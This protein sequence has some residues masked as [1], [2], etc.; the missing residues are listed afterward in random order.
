VPHG[1]SVAADGTLYLVEMSPP[2]V[3]RMRPL[4]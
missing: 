2:S 1:L 4:P 3:V